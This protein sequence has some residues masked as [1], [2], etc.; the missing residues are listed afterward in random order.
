M[1]TASN[2]RAVHK[3]TALDSLLSRSEFC[4]QYGISYRTAEMLAHKGQG[5]KVTRLG[6]R[7]FYHV[8]DIA[9]WVDNQRK[10]ADARFGKTG[11]K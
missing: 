6:R 4:L 8:E 10:K 7:A 11:A 9:T 5:P 1:Q 2:D 3:P